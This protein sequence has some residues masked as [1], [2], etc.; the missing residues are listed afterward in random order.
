MSHPATPVPNNGKRRLGFLILGVVVLLGAIAYGLYWF[1]DARF[2]E[3]TDD[4]YVAGNVVAITSRENATVMSLHVDNTQTVRQGQLL[5]EMDPATANTNLLAAEANLGRAV[6]LVR[7]EFSSAD[8]FSAQLQQ[9][10]VQLVQAQS[11]Y[12]RRLA[13]SADGAVSG[14]E[15]VC[16]LPRTR[17]RAAAGRAV[18]FRQRRARAHA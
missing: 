4:S 18:D 7:G 6:R 3:S 5:I 14:E 17:W 9:A 10:N 8:T 11:D 2:Y 12:R 1:L 16:T 13:A 15:A